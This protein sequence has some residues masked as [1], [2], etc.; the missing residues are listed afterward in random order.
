MGTIDLNDLSLFV[1]VVEAGSF[2]KA[3]QRMRLPKSSVSRAITR[4]ED[5]IGGRILHR[6]TRRIALSTAGKA[7]YDKVQ[8][9]V[10]SLRR[11]IG[12]LPELEVEPSGHLRITCA[13]G[14]EPYL[15]DIVS[16]FVNR[17]K[18]VEIELRLTNEYVDLVADGIDLALRFSTTYLKGASLAARK[19]CPSSVN[20]YA[21]PSYAARRGLPKTPRDLEGHDMVVYSRKTDLILKDDGGA[22]TAQVFMRGRIICDD[23]A[24]V[25]AALV[26]GSGIGYLP[27]YFAEADVA[28]GALVRVLPR[29]SSPLSNLWAVWVG[30]RKLPRRISAFLDFLLESLKGR[31]V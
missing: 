23:L 28:T 9:D 18:A 5:A 3:A 8:N 29:W 17:H 7:L 19:I 25:R 13:L 1:T 12:E 31:T 22:A 26:N 14:C 30:G 4:L 10:A 16:R 20:L 24:F 27:P 21:A 15:A 2:S 11:S 6:T